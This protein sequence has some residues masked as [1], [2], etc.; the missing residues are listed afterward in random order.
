MDEPTSR[1]M[2]HALFYPS[3]EGGRRLDSLT[4]LVMDLMM[5]VEALRTALAAE[6]SYRDA[7]RETGLLTHNSAGPSMGWDKL[8]DEFYPGTKD[9]RGRGWRE[10]LMLRRLGYSPD[11]IEA[12]RRDAEGMEVLT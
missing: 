7:Y 3:E 6:S 4:I 12:Y 8:L 9:G 11:E 1:E 2:A 5:E 10:S